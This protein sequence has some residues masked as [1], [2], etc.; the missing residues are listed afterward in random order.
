MYFPPFIPSTPT[1]SVS[2]KLHLEVFFELC[3]P[4]HKLQPENLQKVAFLPE[5]YPSPWIV[6]KFL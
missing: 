6:E 4:F 2:Q 5:L 1:K 3:R